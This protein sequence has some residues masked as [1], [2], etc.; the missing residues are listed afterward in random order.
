MLAHN[1]WGVY[2]L[3]KTHYNRHVMNNG[4]TTK[5]T[6]LTKYQVYLTEDLQDAFTRYIHDQFS[7]ND[8]VV[9]AL[10]RKAITLFLIQKGYIDDNKQ[11]ANIDTDTQ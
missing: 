1:D 11:E 6:K 7:P 3:V 5:R 2:K 8:R 4:I 9:T 10:I